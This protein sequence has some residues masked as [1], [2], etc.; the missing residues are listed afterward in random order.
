VTRLKWA[1]IVRSRPEKNAVAIVTNMELNMQH[2]P[3][4]HYGVVARSFHWGMALLIFA[5][6]AGVELHGFFEK[7]GDVRA[8]LMS[9]HFQTGLAVFALIWFRLGAVAFR[10]VPPIIPEPP[11]WQNLAAKFTHLAF[12]AAMIA[13]PVL[14]L[15]GAQA[16]GKAVNLLGMAMPLFTGEDKAFAKE[17][18]EIHETIGNVMIGLIVAH[19][20]AAYWHHFKQRDNTLLRMLPPK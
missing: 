8:A 2:N 9:I 10:P 15:L 12:Y 13:L 14:G 5:G 6:L 20:A 19:I 18:R 16:S 7:G 1:I 3:P 11:Q 4:S 17:I